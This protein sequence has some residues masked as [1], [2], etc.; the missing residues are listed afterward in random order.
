LVI[1]I[2]LI[3]LNIVI[4]K[5]GDGRRMSDNE[6]MDAWL[7]EYTTKKVKDKNESALSG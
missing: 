1:Y 7:G 4:L 3:S 2:L 5:K 6:P